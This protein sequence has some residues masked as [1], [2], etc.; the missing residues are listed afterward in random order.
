MLEILLETSPGFVLEDALEVVAGNTNFRLALHHSC[1]S[2][3]AVNTEKL[4]AESATKTFLVFGSAE[5]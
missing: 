2:D 5:N 3:A 1:S 4:P